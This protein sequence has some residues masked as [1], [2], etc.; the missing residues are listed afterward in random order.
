[1]PDRA[2]V[3]AEVSGNAELPFHDLLHEFNSDQNSARVVEGLETEHRLRAEFDTPVV[4]LDH[5]VQVLT[6]ANVDWILPPVIK[7]VTHPRL[8]VARNGLVRS[9]PA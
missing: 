8:G 9:R 5:I 7:F 3:V 2:S 1:L 6:T 4:L